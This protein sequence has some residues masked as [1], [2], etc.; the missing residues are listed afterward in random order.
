MRG[1][2]AAMLRGFL[3]IATCACV[4]SLRAPAHVS[5]CASARHAT[6]IA[7]ISCLA[8]ASKPSVHVEYS[9]GNAYAAF[10]AVVIKR[11]GDKVMISGTP[12]PEPDT[13]CFEVAVAISSQD[14]QET[15]AVY[16]TGADWTG[17]VSLHSEANGDKPGAMLKE[18]ELEAIADRFVF[19]VE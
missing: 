3:V 1:R 4:L 18:E 8:P 16:R 7:E 10:E 9:D 11:F 12:T 13:E 5:Q 17:G 15:A 19:M 2:N 14:A 6:R